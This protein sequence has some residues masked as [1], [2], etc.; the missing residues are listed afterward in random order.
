VFKGG[1]PV[2]ALAACSER[3]MT[4]RRRSRSV[5][6]TSRQVVP[7]CEG[8]E[9]SVAELAGLTGASEMTIRRDLES[10]RR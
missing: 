9:R 1:A 5:R 4:V 2:R 7:P 10:L 6:A 8:A 3:G